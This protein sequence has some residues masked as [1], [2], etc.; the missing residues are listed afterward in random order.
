M[1]ATETVD[2]L[3]FDPYDRE[4]MLNPHP[5]C[6]RLREEAPLYHNEKVGFYALSRA[7]D[8]ERAALDRETL[9]SGRGATLEQLKSGKQMPPGT[10]LME[11]PPAHTIHRGLLSR[12]FAPRR[13][14]SL[15]SR[16]RQLCCE[17]LDP[18]VDTG[19]FDMVG[20]FASILPATV[21]GQLVGIPDEDQN[22]I[23]EYIGGLRAKGVE[24]RFVGG[25]FANYIDWRVDHPSDDVMTQLMS[26]EFEDETGTRRRLTRNEVLAYVNLL[27]LAGNDTTTIALGW[28]AK[29]LAE[30][31]DQR[32]LLVEDPSLIPGGFEEILRF[33]PPTVE[34]CRYVAR[35]VEYYGHSVPEGSIMALLFVSA[36]RDDR[37]FSDPD[38]FDV[39]RPVERHFTFGFG[40]HY[41]L[42][43]ALA[44]LVGSVALEEVLKRLPEWDVDLERGMFKGSSDVRG[45]QSLPIIIP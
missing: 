23:R 3:Y 28:A 6:R 16:I 39:C 8:V 31:P 29:L 37:R 40:A 44:R 12:M 33:E 14:A 36:N 26:A 27:V 30:H 11:D 45:W 21:V 38:R 19:G 4:T 1:T 22:S 20:D 15:Q 24:D 25:F 43:Q 13:I 10:V 17:L 2:D 32:A 18:L 7:E 41:C 34:A 42:G 9:I 35:D 5:V